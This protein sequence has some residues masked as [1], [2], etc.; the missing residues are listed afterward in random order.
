MRPQATGSWAL[1]AVVLAAACSPCAGAI[2]FESLAPG[3]LFGT[4]THAPGDEVDLG[5]DP[6]IRVELQNFIIGSSEL[7][8]FATVEPAGT[9]GL[10]TQSLALDNISLQFDLTDIG[11]DVDLVSFE[12]ADLGGSSNIRV[13][14]GPLFV[15]DPLTDLP[16]DVGPGVTATVDQGLVTFSGSIQSLLVGG[17][18]LFVDNIAFVPEPAAGLL[19][20]AGSICCWRRRRHKGM[21]RHPRA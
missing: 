1:V 6:G 15:L 20:V 9:A 8:F 16:Q 2:D 18:E 7:F 10:A 12:F 3:T 13:N 17:Q 14:G 21:R 5:Q 4:P 11:Y 19:L